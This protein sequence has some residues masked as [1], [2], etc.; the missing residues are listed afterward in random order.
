MV[1]VGTVSEDVKICVLHPQL[2]GCSYIIHSFVAKMAQECFGGCIY[3]PPRPAQWTHH[4]GD[5]LVYH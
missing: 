4:N 2:T 5:P 3:E 1:H